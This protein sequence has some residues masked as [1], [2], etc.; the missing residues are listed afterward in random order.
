MALNMSIESIDFA[1]PLTP[2]E[3][4]NTANQIPV[5]DRF[6]KLEKDLGFRAQID[7]GEFIAYATSAL[8]EDFTELMRDYVKHYLVDHPGTPHPTN[9]IHQFRGILVNLAHIYHE[10]CE[11]KK[12]RSIRERNLSYVAKKMLDTECT[13]HEQCDGKQSRDITDIHLSYLTKEYLTA[14]CNDMRLLH[15]PIDENFM[16]LLVATG[17]KNPVL[18]LREYPIRFQSTNEIQVLSKIDPS[19]T[20]LWYAIR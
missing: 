7:A 2:S 8:D 14:V 13:Y 3:F 15:E 4:E 9:E 20:P 17:A 6:Q 10:R 19:I 18:P 11:S 12:L 1:P 16:A 5:S